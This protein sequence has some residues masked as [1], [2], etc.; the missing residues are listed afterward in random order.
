MNVI[1][2]Q[3]LALPIVVVCYCCC[4]TGAAL[5]TIFVHL[6]LDDEVEEE[7]D[8]GDGDVRER[9]GQ[10][11][12]I[13]IHAVAI[14]G[15]RN[16]LGVERFQLIES[17]SEH[18]PARLGGAHDVQHL[19]VNDA[20]PVDEVR[21]PIKPDISELVRSRRTESARGSKF[22]VIG[23]ISNTQSFCM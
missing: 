17:A 23:L 15:R 13:F 12:V 1:S 16:G 4:P 5:K 3:S 10:Q 18:F 14:L 9:E 11:E 19:A 8:D 7:V 21:D 20:L 22:L 6:P 2:R